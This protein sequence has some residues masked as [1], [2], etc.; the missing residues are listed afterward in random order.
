[1]AIKETLKNGE[2]SARVPVDLIEALQ[3]L[4]KRNERTMSAEVRL[5]IKDHLAKEKA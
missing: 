2:L 1:M 3:A 4:A 5:A